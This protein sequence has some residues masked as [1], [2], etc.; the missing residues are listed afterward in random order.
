MPRTKQGRPLDAV[1]YLH[2]LTSVG[3][4]TKL[5]QEI[6]CFFFL[7]SRVSLS[8]HLWS[9][10]STYRSYFAPILNRR[11]QAPRGRRVPRISK[12][13]PMPRA[14]NLT[15]PRIRNLVRAEEAEVGQRRPHRHLPDIGWTAANNG[16]ISGRSA[17]PDHPVGNRALPEERGGINRSGYPS[18][19]AGSGT[20]HALLRG[21]H[22]PR[23]SGRDAGTSQG[24]ARDGYGELGGESMFLAAHPLRSG[25][26]EGDVNGRDGGLLDPRLAADPWHRRR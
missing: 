3:Q 14:E 17:G 6:A 5:L 26:E 13:E 7:R 1:K 16:S 19:N 21:G 11:K 22:D 25:V 20:V 23:V 18:S 15:V 10:N 8:C 4:C 9:S 12:S 24:N 2:S